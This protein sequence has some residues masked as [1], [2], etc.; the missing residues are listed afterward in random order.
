MRSIS[1]A[2]FSAKSVKNFE[3]PYLSMAVRVRAKTSS[4]R[5]SSLK[6]SL[7]NKSNGLSEKKFAI[8]YIR[9][10][11]KPRLLSINANTTSPCESLTS[12]RVLGR[13][14]SIISINLIDLQIP[15]T[16]PR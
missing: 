16:T 6:S 8:W 4:L 10:S 5:N 1:Q 15:V 7:K 14:E 13:M 12:P 2:I 9:R 11:L 3:H